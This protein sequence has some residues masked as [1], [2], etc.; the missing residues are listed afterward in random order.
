DRPVPADQFLAFMVSDAFQSVIPTTN[1]MYP[2]V[3]PEAGLPDGFET[4]LD[5]DGWLLLP[6]DMAA[7]QRDAALDAWRTALS[8]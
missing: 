6:P 8:Q 5:P 7:S 2:A 4:L 1:W 3:I